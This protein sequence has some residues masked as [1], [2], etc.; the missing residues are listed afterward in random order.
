MY[1]SSKTLLTEFTILGRS[2]NFPEGGYAAYGRMPSAKQFG[3]I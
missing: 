2:N 3:T 1:K